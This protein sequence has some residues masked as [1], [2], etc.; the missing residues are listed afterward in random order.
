MTTGSCAP[1]AF[2]NRPLLRDG[3]DR[4]SRSSQRHSTDRTR[5]S[6]QSLLVV[7]ISSRCPLD[8]GVASAWPPRS[9]SSS[10]ATSSLLTQ[11]LACRYCPFS[12]ARHRERRQRRRRRPISASRAR[13]SPR[14]R[15][16]SARPRLA[17]SPKSARQPAVPPPHCFRVASGPST[18]A[19]FRASARVPTPVYMTSSYSPLLG[20]TS[21]SRSSNY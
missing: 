20:W 10:V 14:S 12:R 9:F 11:G 19:G 4:E 18:R 21:F 2:L 1:L 13:L 6:S 5:W 17:T 8:F 3:D 7:A 16:P 15:G